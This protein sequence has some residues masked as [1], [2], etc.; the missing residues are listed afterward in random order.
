MA[1]FTCSDIFRI[2]ALR[3]LTNRGWQRWPSVRLAAH[4]FGIKNIFEILVRAQGSLKQ[5]VWTCRYL[6]LKYV[7]TWWRVET[8]ELIRVGWQQFFFLWASLRFLVWIGMGPGFFDF[9]CVLAICSQPRE[10]LLTFGR[11][12]W[13]SLVWRLILVRFRSTDGL[14][15]LHFELLLSPLLCIVILFLVC[16]L[17]LQRFFFQVLDS[18]LNSFFLLQFTLKSF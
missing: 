7:L 10:L 4:I 1:F 8:F 12:T 11:H 5:M 14:G 9:L 18:L 16:L 6:F 3:F 2:D 13:T 15:L 17:F